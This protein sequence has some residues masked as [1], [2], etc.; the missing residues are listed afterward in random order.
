MS[1]MNT[2]ILSALALS[3]LVTMCLSNCSPPSPDRGQRRTPQSTMVSPDRPT[4]D[5]EETKELQTAMSR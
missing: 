4:N 5:L 2:K 3:L 1:T